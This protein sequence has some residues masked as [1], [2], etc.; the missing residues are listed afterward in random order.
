MTYTKSLQKL[1][2]SGASFKAKKRGENGDRRKTAVN[3]FNDQKNMCN[4]N[5]PVTAAQNKDGIITFTC[6]CGHETKM[7]LNGFYMP[8]DGYTTHCDTHPDH[9]AN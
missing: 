7:M 1:R 9:D 2:I 8:I 6:P 4:W 5:Q 3:H